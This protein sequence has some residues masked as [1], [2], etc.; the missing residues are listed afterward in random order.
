MERN[1]LYTKQDF[2]ALFQ[3][4][5]IR[6]GDVVLAQIDLSGLQTVISSEQAVIEALQ[7]TV[8]SQG[9]IIVPTFS[10][11]CLDPSCVQASPIDYEDW[12]TVRENIIGFRP[13]LTP[14]DKH[15]LFSNQ[16]LK[17]HQVTRTGHP[18]Y[19]FAYWGKM[20]SKWLEQTMDFPVS[21]RHVLRPFAY[22]QAKN[23]L[24]GVK[25]EESV[26]LPAIAK[27]MK[28]GQTMTERAFYKENKKTKVKNFL[29]T[30]LQPQQVQNCLDLC[31]IKSYEF[32]DIDIY[33]MTL[34]Q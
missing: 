10:R 22:D 19:S 29:H 16:F 9:C 15:P 25:K 24:M 3:K 13:D 2:K 23:I 6:K 18:V 20:D 4:I 26:L 12:S 5:G 11:S 34:D 17:N 27:T 1:I 33:V 32:K 14:S 7:E 21:F 28:Q 30:D 31:Y 8:E